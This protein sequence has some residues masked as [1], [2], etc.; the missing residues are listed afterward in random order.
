MREERFVVHREDE[1]RH[2]RDGFL[3]LPNELKPVR[4]AE[5]QVDDREVGTFG[6]REGERLLGRLGLAADLQIRFGGDELSHAEP[7]DGMVVDDQNPPFDDRPGWHAC[8]LH[9][10]RRPHVRAL[11]ACT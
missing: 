8:S 5:R 7:D 9:D 4:R 3:E 6:Q 1:D 2:L 11:R 10:R